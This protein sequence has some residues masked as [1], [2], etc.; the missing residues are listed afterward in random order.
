MLM[1][2]RPLEFYDY[3]ASQAPAILNQTSSEPTASR[4]NVSTVTII[5]L[6]A[7]AG[8]NWEWAAMILKQIA[9]HSKAKWNQMIK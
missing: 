9:I 6:A 2:F 3:C 7:L 5:P 1:A 4:G 8:F